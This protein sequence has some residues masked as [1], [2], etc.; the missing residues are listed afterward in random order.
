MSWA[1]PTSLATAMDASKVCGSVFGLDM[2]ALAWTYWPPTWP[3]TSAYSFSAPTATILPSFEAAVAPPEHAA[4]TV[5]VTA[6]ITASSKMARGRL[7]A[8]RRAPALPASVLPA[9][10]RIPRSLPIRPRGHISARSG[11]K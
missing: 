2:M 9:L 6:A 3:S 7:P 8:P 10:P 11:V 5:A 1:L 4:T